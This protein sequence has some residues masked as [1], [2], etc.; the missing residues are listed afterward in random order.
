LIRIAKPILE[1]SLRGGH[2]EFQKG[3]R[4]VIYQAQAACGEGAGPKNMDRLERTVEQ[5]K[6]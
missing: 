6:N 1:I 3:I 2:N 4:L 5:A